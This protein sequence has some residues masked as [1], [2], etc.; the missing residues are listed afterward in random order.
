MLMMLYLKV[1][2]DDKPPS[3]EAAMIQS[4]NKV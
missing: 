1:S 2:A 3:K 4:T